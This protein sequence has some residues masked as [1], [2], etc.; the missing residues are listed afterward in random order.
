MKG[1]QLPHIEHTSISVLV[2]I[3]VFTV[4]VFTNI[5]SLS[6]FSKSLTIFNIYLFIISHC[7]NFGFLY[8]SCYVWNEFLQIP[9]D[10]IFIS[11]I[12]VCTL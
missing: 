6:V 12:G 2:V 3:S 5:T 10:I 8:Y 4:K 1:D 11:L 7:F 9:E